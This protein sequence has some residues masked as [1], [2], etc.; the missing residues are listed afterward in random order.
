MKGKDQIGKALG[1]VPSGLFVV[2]TKFEDREDAVL[3]SWVNQCSFEPPAV[4]IVLA[5]VRPARL[6]IEASGAF[7][8]NIL[9]EESKALMKHF[10]Q[11][12]ADDIFKGLKT[13][14]GHH[15]I[16]ILSDAV[17]CLECEVTDSAHSGDHVMYIGGITGGKMLKGGNPYIHVRSNGFNY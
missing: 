17:A 1:R 12:A 16:R 7:I 14:K 3:A 15:G 2:T 10:F 5:T 8:V 11:P 13:K 6:L 4:S 9:G